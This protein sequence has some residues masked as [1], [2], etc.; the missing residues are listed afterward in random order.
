M[1]E[2]FRQYG[3]VIISVIAAILFFTIAA[4]FFD[5]NNGELKEIH[6]EYMDAVAYRDFPEQEGFYL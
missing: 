2:V 6:T 1:H 3:A 5:T 4:I